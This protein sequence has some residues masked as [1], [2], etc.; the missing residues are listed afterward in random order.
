M[1]QAHFAIMKC[2]LLDGRGTLTVE[3]NVAS[4]S[5][6]VHIDRSKIISHGKPAL[7]EML[8]RLHMYR[9]TADV[10]ACSHTIT[11]CHE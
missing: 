4:Q 2:L 8:L 7:G 9:C 10:Q 5:L 11:I 1:L 6:T 3:C